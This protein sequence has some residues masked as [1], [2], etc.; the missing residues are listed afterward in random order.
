LITICIVGAFIKM[1]TS[2]KQ[3][4]KNAVALPQLWAVIIPMQF[5]GLYAIYNILIGNAPNWWIATLLGYICFKMIGIAAGYHRLFCHRGFTVNKIVKR[6]ILYFGMLGG[7]GSPI[8]WV[9]I[10]R[11]YHHRYAD[12]DKDLHSPRDGIWHSYIGW[13]FKCPTLNIRSAIDLTSDPDMVWAHKY[14]VPTIYITH[15]VAALIS[16]DLWL[17]LFMLPMFI[18]LHCFL[19]QTCFTHISALGYR[20]YN[21]NNTSINAPILFPFILGEA[22][23]NNHH[24]DGRNPNYSRRW[25]ELDPTFW[26]IQIIRNDR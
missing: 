4:L 1:E 19:M 9:A 13:M 23:H 16:I 22:W 8:I 26:I 10:H 18:T 2:Y 21:V 24:G 12:T 3:L 15:I 5:F 14:Y 17:Y 6:I 11:G 20:N 7:Q 25:W